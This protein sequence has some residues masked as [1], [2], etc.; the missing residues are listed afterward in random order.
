MNAILSSTK[1][2][3]GIPAEVTDFDTQLVLYI[4]MALTT[5]NHIGFGPEEYQITLTDGDLEDFLPDDEHVRSLVQMYIFTKV[6]VLFDPPSSSYVLTAL[7]E[8]IAEYEWR[9]SVYPTS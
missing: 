4:N 9:L 7:K 3:L 2:L 5:L 6:K 1:E 8:T